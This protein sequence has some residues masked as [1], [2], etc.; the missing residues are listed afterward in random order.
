ML[1]CYSRRESDEMKSQILIFL[2][3]TENSTNAE[4]KKDAIAKIKC[5]ENVIMVISNICN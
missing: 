3:T 5:M 1:I 2:Q 4:E